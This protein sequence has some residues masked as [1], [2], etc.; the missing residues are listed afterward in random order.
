VIS[1]VPPDVERLL[2]R[3]AREVRPLAALTP[4]DSVRE[5]LRLVSLLR[6]G[7]PAIPQWTYAPVDQCELRRGLEAAERALERGLASA[8]EGLY[9]A[10]IRELSIEAA[11]CAA[12]GTRQIASLALRRF[13]PA[14]AAIAGAATSLRAAWLALDARREDAP[15]IAS[16][17]PHPRSLLSQMRAA[18]GR[19]RLPFAVVPRRDLAALAAT[20][21]RAIYVAAGRALGPDD[22]ARTV[23]HEIEGHA[24][25]RARA[26]LAGS[27]LF[28]AGTARGTD[29]Q[30]GR[31]LLLEERAGFLSDKR[32]HQ[33][34]AR[35]WAVEAMLAGASFADVARSLVGD[36]GFDPGDAVLIAER[37]F[38]GGDGE[39]PGLGRERVYLESLVRMRDHLAHHPQDER[40]LA[41][42]Q[43]AIEAV[44]PLR[45]YAPCDGD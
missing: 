42:G 7:R 45:A 2:L 17:D 38:R 37:A 34:A 25:P 15:S 11:L 36:H 21:D 26:A 30:E 10:R 44:E 29:D 19:L 9:L 13:A 8:V 14:N 39:H 31:A 23:L 24:R 28:R 35:H 16:D 1:A 33:L 6:S 40:V 5:R 12:A 18:V 4:V 20:G 32:R 43:V 41:C 22:A 3:A 27:H